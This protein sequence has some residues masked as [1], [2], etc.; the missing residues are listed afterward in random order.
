MAALVLAFLAFVFLNC[1]G[2]FFPIFKSGLAKSLNKDFG[3]S[4]PPSAAVVSA[5]RIALM[6]TSYYYHVTVTP[7]DVTPFI[8]AL[9]AAASTRGHHVQTGDDPSR[10]ALKNKM[11][12]PKPKWWTVSALPDTQCFEVYIEQPNSSIYGYKIFY[13]VSTGHMFV[14]YY[15][16]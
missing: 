14:E 4:L 6:D 15:T 3:I 11:G 5:D 2:L 9:S 13:S 12:Y 10:I 7:A 16:T 1:S 8:A